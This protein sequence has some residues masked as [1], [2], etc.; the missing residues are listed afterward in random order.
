[1]YWGPYADLIDGEHEGY[2]A[3]KMPDGTLSGTWGGEYGWDGHVGFVAACDCGWT[4]QTVYPP[5]DYDSP[6]Y[7]AAEDAW[8][9]EH[10][11]PLIAKAA[12]TWPAWATTMS[13]RAEAIAAHVNAG[14]LADAGDVLARMADDL[15]LR[16]RIVADLTAQAGDHGDA[17]GRS[18]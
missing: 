7:Q 6:G 18:G 5:G 16:Q 13:R 2:A 10:L 1:M 14:R 9:R 4:G 3:R 12:G 8:D 15:R 11:Q 17:A